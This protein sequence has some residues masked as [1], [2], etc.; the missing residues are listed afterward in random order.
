MKHF[1]TTIMAICSLS[2]ALISQTV[3]Q[4]MNYQAVAR[5]AGGQIMADQNINL[6]ISLLGQSANGKT[7]YSEFHQVVTNEIGLFNLTIGEGKKSIGE[8]A[9]VPWSTTEIWMDIALAEGDNAEYKSISTTRL[10]AVPYAFHAGTASEVTG[11]NP[12]E[13]LTGP[14]WKSNGNQAVTAPWQFL[15]TVDNNPLIIKTNNQERMTVA[16]DGDISFSSPLTLNNDLTVNGKSNL[17][18][19][20]IID[21]NIN[22]INGEADKNN[23]PLI[24]TGGAQGIAIQVDADKDGGA[25]HRNSN[26]LTCFDGSGDPMGR[27]EG[28]QAL[29]DATAMANGFNDLTFLFPTPSTAFFSIVDAILDGGSSSNAEQNNINNNTSVS[30][31][32]QDALNAFVGAASNF[33]SDFGVGIVSGT[34]DIANSFIAALADI[35][36]CAILVGCDDLIVG[37]INLIHSV[38]Q[39]GLHVGY[40]SIN[41]GVAFES[42][43][44]DY[45][46][47]LQK[48]DDAE[49]FTYGEVVGIKGGLISKEFTDA[50]K[51]MVVSLNPTVIGAMPKADQ[52]HL[53]EKIAFMGQVPVKVIGEVHKGDY[54]LPSGNGDGLAVAVHPDAMKA[55]DYNRIIGT[56]W[57]ESDG[58]KIY[59]Y[60]NTA[61]GINANDMADMVEQMQMVLNEMQKALQQVNPDYNPHFYDVDGNIEMASSY[62]T[63]PTLNEVIENRINVNNYNNSDVQVALQDIKQD[64]IAQGVNLDQFPYLSDILDN[65]FDEALQAEAQAYYSAVIVRTQYLLDHLNGK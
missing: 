39:L 31:A 54:I 23:Y 24:V 1:F 26:F 57:G 49:V 52:E 3:P 9:E 20:V 19:Q 8:F 4:G 17:N 59:D 37:V 34:L 55:K 33:N 61:V 28:F 29:N 41:P 47:W 21:A 48:A 16:G 36:G 27:I 13:K 44:A 60:V 64:A 2:F 18:D 32:S 58:E 63:A 50:E 38:L 30:G 42:G 6:K 53:Y 11:E 45:A 62:T 51:F 65:P 7:V 56:A 5:D 43:G 40:F 12:D 35:P 15:G 14:Y 46:E 22:A 25:L 10:L